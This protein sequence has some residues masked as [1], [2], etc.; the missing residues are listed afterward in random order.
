MQ[1]EIVMQSENKAQ[2]LN[3]INLTIKILSQLWKERN[4]II[5]DHKNPEIRN[6]VQRT[7]RMA[8][9]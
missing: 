2:G 6:I 9:I 8:E 1:W 5:F 4:K 7:T 3:G